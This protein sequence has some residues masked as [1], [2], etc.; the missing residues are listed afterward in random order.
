[1]S[2]RIHVTLRLPRYLVAEIDR[3]VNAVKYIQKLNNVKPNFTR[4]KWITAAI[5]QIL[6]NSK[7]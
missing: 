7:D 1:M 3:R 2:E 5:M 4:T 6:Q